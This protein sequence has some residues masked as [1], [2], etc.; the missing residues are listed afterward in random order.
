MTTG[1]TYTLQRDCGRRSQALPPWGHR[2][3]CGCYVAVLRA[4]GARRWPPAPSAFTSFMLQVAR[5]P[6]SDVATMPEQ[7]VR[8]LKT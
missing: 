8:Y 4:R 3:R 2:G 5:A 7:K 1:K 6:S